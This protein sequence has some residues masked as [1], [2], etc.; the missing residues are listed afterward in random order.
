MAAETLRYLKEEGARQVLVTN[1]TREKA[2]DIAAECGGVVWP[3][4]ELDRGLA[5][6][7]VIVSTTGAGPPL[8]DRGRFRRGRATQGAKP[9]V[10]P[11][12]GVPRDCDPAASG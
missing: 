5:E 3:F 2:E 4:E 8:L 10:I 12:L 7:D 6:A 1:R 9:A 11:H